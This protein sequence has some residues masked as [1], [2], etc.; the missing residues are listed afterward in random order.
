M[1]GGVIFCVQAARIE[2]IENKHCSPPIPIPNSDGHGGTAEIKHDR[3]DL[4]TIINDC[5]V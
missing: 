5:N 3:Y 2:K 1:R 4:T